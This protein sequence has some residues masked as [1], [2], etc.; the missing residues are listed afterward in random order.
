MKVVEYKVIKDEL[1]SHLK[2][3]MLL[4]IIGS[5]FTRD[6]I[7][8]NGKV[9]SGADYRQYM[10]NSLIESNNFTEKENE[11]IKNQSF[12]NICDIY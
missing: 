2:R 4:P 5:G 12:S 9:P 8:S 10:I 1:L 11:E 7:A 3:K 6:C